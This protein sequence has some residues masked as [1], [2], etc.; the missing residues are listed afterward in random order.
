MD[1][2]NLVWWVVAIIVILIIAAFGVYY[3][4]SRVSYAPS[5]TVSQPDSATA[6]EADLKSLDLSGLGSELSNIDKE[7][8][9]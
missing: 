1:N 6:I 7:L 3:M 4:R 9:K 8:A 2:K 5:P